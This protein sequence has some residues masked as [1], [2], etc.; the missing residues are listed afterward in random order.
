MD[1]FAS[2]K[3]K[4]SPSLLKTPQPRL[5]LAIS[6][7]IDSMVL[8]DLMARLRSSSPFFAVVAHLNHNLRGKASQ[9]DAAFVRQEA[10]KRGLLCELKKLPL[11][12]LKKGGN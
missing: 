9:G 3:K 10:E 7:G 2:F 1:F 6:G 12:K 4:I 5:V 11:G 8:L